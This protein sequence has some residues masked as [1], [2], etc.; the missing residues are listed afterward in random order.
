MRDRDQSPQLG[1]QF[2]ALVNQ[3]LLADQIGRLPPLNHLLLLLNLLGTIRPEL[4]IDFLYL[5]LRQ[6]GGRLDLLLSPLQSAH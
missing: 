2:L 6:A 1:V 5:R 3:G 4:L